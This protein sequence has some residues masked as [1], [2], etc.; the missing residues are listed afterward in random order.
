MKRKKRINKTKKI[1]TSKLYLLLNN[2]IF[3][4]K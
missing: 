1:K 4:N 2:Y 3:I